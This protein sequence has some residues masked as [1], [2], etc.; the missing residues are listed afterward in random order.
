[1]Y[2]NIHLCSR[3][4]FAIW[5]ARAPKRGSAEFTRLS[6]NYTVPANGSGRSKG[7]QAAMQFAALPV[8]MLMAI[9]T[10][11]ITGATH[12][13]NLFFILHQ[14]YYFSTIKVNSLHTII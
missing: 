1:M 11:L 9:L 14:I 4:L 13:V 8:T 6:Q 2:I 5:P 12:S 10:G 7:G 3:S